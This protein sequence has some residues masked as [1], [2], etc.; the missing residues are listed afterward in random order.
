[1]QHHVKRKMQHMEY[2]VS[3][4]ELIE[5]AKRIT[6]TYRRLSSLTGITRQVFWRANR[7]DTKLHP[8]TRAKLFKVVYGK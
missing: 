4:I 7:G 8:P 5:A 3:D 6:G 2:T 1:M